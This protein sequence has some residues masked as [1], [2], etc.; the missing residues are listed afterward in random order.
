MSQKDLKTLTEK[1]DGIQTKRYNLIQEMHDLTEKTSFP[2]EAQKRWND[3]DGEQKTLETEINTLTRTIE[4]QEEMR[5]FQKPPANQ[6]GVLPGVVE[7]DIRTDAKQQ[8]AV[9]KRAFETYVRSGIVACEREFGTPELRTYT[10]L[11]TGSGSQ[12]D[13]TVPIGFQKELEIKMKAYGGM[14]NDARVILTSIGN[15]IN[16]PTVDDT[17]NKGRW[18][19]ENSAVSQTNPTFGQVNLTSNLASSD[20]VLISVQLLNDS[21]FDLYKELTD[22]F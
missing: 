17:T 6:P 20:Q 5:S 7:A 4:L 8:E 21:A 1:R 15:E 19:T 18:L 13:F 12:G 16:W 3:L 22:M 11:N 14:L 2:A 9:S 10:G